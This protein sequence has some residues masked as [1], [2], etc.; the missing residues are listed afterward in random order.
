MK[1]RLSLAGVAIA[2]LLTTAAIGSPASADPL[3]SFGIAGVGT[4]TVNTGDIT[5][6]T[7][8]KTI[9]GT[10]EVSGTTTLTTFT[11]AGLTNGGA[12]TFSTLTF[13]TTNGP[14]AFTM[15]AGDLTFSF[16]DVTL[17]DIVPSGPGTRGSISEQFNGS[18]TGDTS[19]F[20]FL[21]QTASLSETCTQSGVGSSITCSESVRTPGLPP[22]GVPEPASLTF[23]GSALIG[24]F[25]LGWLRRRHMS[26]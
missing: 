25:G 22:T 3:L 1:N 17:A 6:A 15:V 9:P 13:N 23:F 20:G 16:T 12:V 10:E 19:G 21:N 7:T 4:F 8:T 24:L 18:V 14:D 5:A 11:E 26:V 2:A